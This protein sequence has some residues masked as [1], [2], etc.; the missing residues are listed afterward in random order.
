MFL[1]F[2]LL[3]ISHYGYFVQSQATYCLELIANNN[4]NYPQTLFGSCSP[5]GPAYCTCGKYAKTGLGVNY[6]YGQVMC[7][8]YCPP[9]TKQQSQLECVPCLAGYYSGWG[10]CSCKVCPAGKYSDEGQP[11]CELCPAGTF[12]SIGAQVCV[13]CSNS[14]YSAP[15]ASVCVAC[16]A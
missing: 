16:S 6:N 4:N 14:M 1:L 2:V 10:S 13:P 7:S 5:S 3:F 12:S 9:G 11:K 8:E 15:G